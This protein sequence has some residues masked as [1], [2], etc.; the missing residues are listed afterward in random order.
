MTTEMSHK[1]ATAAEEG[2]HVAPEKAP[3]KKRARKKGGCAQSEEKHQGCQGRPAPERPLRR[4]QQQERRGDRHDEA[5]QG[6]HGAAAALD[7]GVG[8]D[9]EDPQNAPMNTW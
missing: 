1:A 7:S 3:S 9:V 8:P 5:R 4:A 2:A 6:R